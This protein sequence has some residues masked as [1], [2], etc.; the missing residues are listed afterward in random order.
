MFSGVKTQC[1]IV[2][3]V[4]LVALAAA[5]GPPPRPDVVLVTFD[6]TRYDR[7]GCTGG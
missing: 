2:P 4:V 1:T 7:F 5:C 3:V 6:T